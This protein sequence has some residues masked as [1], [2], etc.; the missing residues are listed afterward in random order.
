MTDAAGVA[1]TG[2]ERGEL[3]ELQGILA[4]NRPF[5]VI[6]P[7][8]SV[9]TAVGRALTQ[10]SRIGPYIHEPCD[11]WAHHDGPIRSIS[12]HLRRGAI[13][14]STL[15]KEMT[16]QLGTAEVCDAFLSSA[17]SPVVFLTRDP[18]LSIESRI[19]MVLADILREGR[20]TPDESAAITRALDE[21]DYAALDGVLTEE[22]FPI[23]FTGWDAFAIQVERCR[24]ASIDHLIVDAS[25]FRTH[26]REVLQ[27]TLRRVDLAF[28]E[29]MLAWSDRDRPEIGMEEQGAWYRRVLDSTS[30][31]AAT[32]PIVEVDRFPARF[33]EHLPGALATHER[34]ATLP[35]YVR[36]D[37]VVS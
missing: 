3:D 8:R 18:R 36:V 14:P 22:V 6:S 20:C 21:H 30:I 1:D 7:P 32:E 37:L 35:T 26:P 13:S 12:E 9:S 11:D 25:T 33:R 5:L 23:A 15:I 10:H 27:R 16:F 34:L 2:G 19:R 29:G 31:E 17:H 4:S 28:E 24:E